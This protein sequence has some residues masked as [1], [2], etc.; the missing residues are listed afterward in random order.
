M[1]YLQHLV[2]LVSLLTP[3]C[4]SYTTMHT[5]ETVGSGET[6]VAFGGGVLGG[7]NGVDGE[8]KLDNESIGAL[9]ARYGLSDRVGFGL[10]LNG[11][12]IAGDLNIALVQNSNFAFS[13][14]PEIAAVFQQSHALQDGTLLTP[15]V[16]HH[17]AGSVKL[18]ADIVKT[19]FVDLTVGVEPGFMY[20]TDINFVGKT[21]PFLG[22]SLG[23]R[24][25]VPMGDSPFMQPIVTPAIDV[26][27]PINRADLARPT[28]GYT[29]IFGLTTRL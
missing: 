24:Y 26:M 29:A 18:L 13:V 25:E 7:V 28:F 21:G 10:R 5:A 22:G 1:K 12:G 19:K 6:E 2:L 3:G 8:D 17:L 11:M 27:F 20:A 9:G 16:A 15:K 23:M 14:D 4:F